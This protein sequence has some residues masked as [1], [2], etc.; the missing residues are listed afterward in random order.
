MVSAFLGVK[1]ILS[2]CFITSSELK[3]CYLEP[4]D[5]HNGDAHV[6]GFDIIKQDI[7][8]HIKLLSARNDFTEKEH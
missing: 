4:A 1:V 8:S 2:C 3:V 6:F 7:I 5:Y